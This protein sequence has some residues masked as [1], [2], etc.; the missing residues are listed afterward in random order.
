LPAPSIDSIPEIELEVLIRIMRTSFSI[1]TEQV[2]GKPYS[3]RFVGSP[4]NTFVEDCRAI[5]IFTHNRGRTV[6]PHNTKAVLAKFEIEEA[7]FI[8]AMFAHP[9]S[10]A[11]DGTQDAV[12][13]AKPN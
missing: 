5:Q 11:G 13:E 12:K 2:V 8:E 6:S 4:Y 10:S 9:L 7:L 1:V 3:V